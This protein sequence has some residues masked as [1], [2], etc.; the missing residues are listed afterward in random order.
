[1]WSLKMG[2]GISSIFSWPLTPSVCALPGL[3]PAI[4]LYNPPGDGVLFHPGSN[5]SLICATERQCRKW[6]TRLNSTMRSAAGRKRGRRGRGRRRVMTAVFLASPASHIIMSIGRPPPS[7]TVR[8]LPHYC[9]GLFIYLCCL[10]SNEFFV[11]VV[12]SFCACTSSNNNTYWCLRTINDT[13]NTLF[14]EFATGFLEY[15]DLNSD[16]YQVRMCSFVC[17]ILQLRR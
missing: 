15:F 2:Q 13:H 17:C 12:G 1:M 11:S 14:C 4:S 16:P 8:K 10:E 5:V 9:W 3:P 7:G 6:T